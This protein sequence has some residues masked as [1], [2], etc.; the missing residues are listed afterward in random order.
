MSVLIE[1]SPLVFGAVLALAAINIYGIGLILSTV[2]GWN[3]AASVV[4]GAAIVVAYTLLG[5]FLAVVCGI[6]L[7]WLFPFFSEV[8]MYRLMQALFV[9]VIIGGIIAAVVLYFALKMVSHNIF[10]IPGIDSA[11]KRLQERKKKALEVERKESLHKKQ[12]IR[13]CFLPLS[14][15]PFPMFAGLGTP[16]YPIR[17]G[18]DF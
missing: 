4:L 8:Y 13:P 18:T 3:F 6:G 2:L 17:S 11:I 10:N 5:G 1:S 16:R 12:G 14:F 15:S 9:N 7:S